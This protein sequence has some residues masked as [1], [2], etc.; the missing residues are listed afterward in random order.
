MGKENNPEAKNTT[1]GSMF[2]K[3]AP[4]DA[5]LTKGISAKVWSIKYIGTVRET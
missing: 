1:Q 2:K 5:E 3:P 4:Q